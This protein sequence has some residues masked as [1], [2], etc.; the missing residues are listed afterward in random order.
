MLFSTCALYAT[1]AQAVL[2]VCLPHAY[3]PTLLMLGRA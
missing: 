2:K 1:E 3:S